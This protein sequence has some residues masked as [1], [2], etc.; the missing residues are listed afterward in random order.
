LAIIPESEYKDA[1]ISLA[2]IAADRSYWS[3]E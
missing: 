1:L 2:H 3:L